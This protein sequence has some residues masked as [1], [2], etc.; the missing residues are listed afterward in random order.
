MATNPLGQYPVRCPG[1]NATVFSFSFDTANTAAPDGLIDPCDVINGAG[2]RT[3]QGRLTFTLN[4]RYKVLHVTCN[5]ETTI[6][7]TSQVS[8]VVDGTAAANTI[9]IA[10]VD[11]AL[12]L[13]DTN[14]LTV[15]V[16]VFAYPATS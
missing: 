5:L 10:T 9:E 1:R 2:V 11:E 6:T 16:Q 15:H 8:A 14:N 13:Q 4:D 7:Y 12:A 3:A